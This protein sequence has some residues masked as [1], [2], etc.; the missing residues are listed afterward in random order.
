MTGLMSLQELEEIRAFYAMWGDSKKEA[1]LKQ[2]WDS[3]ILDFL[4]SRSVRNNCLLFKPP[5]LC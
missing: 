2:E 5:S 3:L 1:I 4:V